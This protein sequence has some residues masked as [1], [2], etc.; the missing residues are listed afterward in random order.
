MIP[1][2]LQEIKHPEWSNFRV[3]VARV[4]SEYT[5][6]KVLDKTI[7]LLLLD[8]NTR[9]MPERIY[10]PITTMGFLAMFTFQ[11]DNTKM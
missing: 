4:S 7:I 1:F 8:F 9:T 3:S 5:P 10:N 6:R 11:L 2:W